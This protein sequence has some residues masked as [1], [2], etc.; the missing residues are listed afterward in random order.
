MKIVSNSQLLSSLTSLVDPSQ[1]QQQ[2]TLQD[3][4]NL[5]K[6]QLSPEQTQRISQSDVRNTERQNRIEANRAA[7][8]KLQEKLKAD[9]LEKLKTELSLENLDNQ[10]QVNAGALNRRES[11][12]SRPPQ[13]TRPGQIIDIR[14]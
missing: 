11:L 2:Q 8:A 12:G 6:K 9:N 3:Q 5:K 14:V 1:R 13:D 10:D 7:L 4:Q